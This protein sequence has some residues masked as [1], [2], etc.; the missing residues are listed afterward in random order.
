[1]PRPGKGVQWRSR[2]RRQ[3]RDR[4]HLQSQPGSRPGGVR[5]HV[6][7]RGPAARRTGR[8]GT[9]GRSREP[10]PKPTAAEGTEE[11]L[12]GQE[13]EA[14]APVE[15]PAAEDEEDGEQLFDELFGDEHERE[16]LAPEPEAPAGEPIAPSADPERVTIGQT[17]GL[18]YRLPVEVVRAILGEGAE[19]RV[20]VLR[21]STS[22]AALQ[23]R[24]RASD[25]RCTPM[26]FTSDHPDTV[27][28]LFAGLEIMAAALNLGLSHVS[29][30]TIR[31]EDA[32]A[33]QSHVA[34]M[35][36]HQAQGIR[37][38]SDL[39]R[40]RRRLIGPPR[41]RNRQRLPPRP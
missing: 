24:M 35:L 18:Q 11:A 20:D 1:M 6:R 40:S 9:R 30:I 7:R 8:P 12:G 26:I 38:R 3:R 16:A 29:V 34:H 14:P 2:A 31:T 4:A 10:R 27:P 17:E 32:G 21:T 28:A 33:V 23:K 13:Q 19:E 41:R 37:G 36:I 15:Q 39:A 22:I 5:G 25:G